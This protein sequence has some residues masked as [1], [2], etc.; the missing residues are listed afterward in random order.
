MKTRQQAQSERRRDDDA[1]GAA[2]E[3]LRLVQHQVVPLDA[4]EVLDVLDDELVR[5]D[6]NVEG[7]LAR[8]H[9]FLV[10]E[11]A[12][13][14][15]VLC[16]APVRHHL[17]RAINTLPKRLFLTPCLLRHIHFGTM[18]LHSTER[19]AAFSRFIFEE[20]S[21]EQQRTLNEGMNFD[22][23]CCQL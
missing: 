17:P 6:H 15:P 12:Q 23:S 1:P 22:T 14:L 4:L 7:R 2:L 16:V 9:V 5:S 10:P 8:V 20:C 18:K 3:R 19:S 13:H 21:R 11:L